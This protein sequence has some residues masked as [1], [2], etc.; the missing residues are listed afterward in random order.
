ML[1]RTNPSLVRVFYL[2]VHALLWGSGVCLY[3][4]PSYKVCLGNTCNALCVVRPAPRLHR[5]GAGSFP[6]SRYH[7]THGCAFAC[8]KKNTQ[9]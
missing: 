3:E 9:F 2:C 8:Y 1:G 7:G 5:P 6:C 4:Y